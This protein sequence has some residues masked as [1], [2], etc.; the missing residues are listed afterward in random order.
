MEL[1]WY[2]K[3][4]LFLI[5]RVYM[6]I[7]CMDEDLNLTISPF[8]INFFSLLLKFFFPSTHLNKKLCDHCSRYSYEEVCQLL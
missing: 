2:G 7:W 5:F 3:K 1:R 8:F 4:A 6:G